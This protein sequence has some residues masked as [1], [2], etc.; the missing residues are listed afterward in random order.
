MTSQRRDKIKAGLRKRGIS[1]R[2]AAETLGVTFEHLNRVLNGHRES[3]RLLKDVAEL[4]SK[5][6]AAN[7]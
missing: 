1:Q 2:K 7:V 5:K 6:E 3:A 4:S